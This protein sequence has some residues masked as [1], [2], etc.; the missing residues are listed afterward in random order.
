M[1]SGTRSAEPGAEFGLDVSR[2]LRIR[3]QVDRL[4]GAVLVVALSPVLL[5]LAFVIRTS[6]DK[7]KAFLRLERIGQHG[8]QLR[9][10]KLRTM[11]VASPDGSG[12]G[13]AITAGD[14]DSR[15]TSIGRT[16]RQWRA[17][18]LP[19]LLNVVGGTMALIGPR[20][21]AP[22]YVDQ[23]A[24]AWRHVLSVRPGI[25]GPTQVLTHDWENDLLGVV[26]DHEARYRSEILPVKLAIDRW[27][28]ANAS[29]L[30]DAVIAISLVQRFAGRK[31]ET[32]LHKRALRLIP[33]ARAV[34]LVRD[35]TSAP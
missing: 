15:V 16:L 17:D 33:A 23:T 1:N 3:A 14:G 12:G 20:P 26:D 6:K 35:P 22:N 19:Q 2:W 9:M 34:P 18:E 27:Y 24:D 21:E 13:A 10:W 32:L 31:R 28:V 7:G 25:A 5:V 8:G 11:R 4:L 29:P 30:I